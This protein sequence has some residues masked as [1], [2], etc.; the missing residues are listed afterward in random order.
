MAEMHPL[1]RE[2][3]FFRK[4]G[5]VFLLERPNQR[6]VR[7]VCYIFGLLRMQCSISA[8]SRYRIRKM[9]KL[10]TF[11]N[12]VSH[13]VKSKYLLHYFLI[14]CNGC[15]CGSSMVKIHL[16]DNIVKKNAKTRFVQV[17]SRLK[18]VLR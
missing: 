15:S 16:M 2:D 3:A 4:V 11:T 1:R 14:V 10:Y 9:N 6:N 8:C 12:G 13:H 17:I 18:I 5:F 7:E